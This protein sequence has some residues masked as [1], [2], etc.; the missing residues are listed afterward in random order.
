MFLEVFWREAG[1]V[2]GYAR[3]CV[4]YILRADTSYVGYILCVCGYI[5]VGCILFHFPFSFSKR[6]TKMLPI[7]MAGMRKNSLGIS[8]GLICNL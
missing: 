5:C 1:E 7:Q 2:L 8:S 6:I 4:G 3:A